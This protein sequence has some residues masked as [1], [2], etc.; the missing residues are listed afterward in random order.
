MKNPILIMLSIFITW[1]ILL[2]VIGGSINLYA[3]Q[4]VDR[5]VIP[6]LIPPYQM[7]GDYS[8][9]DL[10]KFNVTFVDDGQRIK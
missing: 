7:I 4:N 6:L 10:K 3:Q 2:D 1:I 5:N 9:F 8:S